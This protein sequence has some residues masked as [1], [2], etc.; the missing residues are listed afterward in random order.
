MFVRYLGLAGLGLMALA[1]AARADMIYALDLPGTCCTGNDFG[2]ITL[3]PVDADTVQVTL[4]LPAGEV[5]AVTGAGRSL[6]FTI[7][8]AFSYVAGSLTNGF[9][10]STS[11]DSAPPYGSFGSYVDCSTACGNGT[12][13]PQFSGPLTFEVFNGAGLSP[14]DFIAKSGG[15]F[16]AADIG[17]PTGG[18]NYSTGNVASDLGVSPDPPPPTTPEPASIVLLATGLG[19]TLW[20]GR[21]R[22]PI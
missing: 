21:K 19:F 1:S 15:H 7:D 16:F 8:E 2:T 17:Q 5:F 12:S 10:G 22:S 18:G 11:G 20:L 4:A 6:E 14:S 3:H 9:I 13:P